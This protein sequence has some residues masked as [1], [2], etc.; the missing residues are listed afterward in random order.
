[1]DAWIWIVLAI[2]ALVVIASIAWGIGRQR[3]STTLREQFGPEYDRTLED[4]DD[5]RAAESELESR[6]ARREQ[7][8]IRPLDAASRQR[9]AEQWEG[10]QAR[11]VDDPEIAVTEADGLIIQVMRDRGYPID[12]FDRRAADVSVDH[13]RVVEHYR[14][15]HEIADRSKSGRATTEDMRK[16]VVHYRALF[17]DLLDQPADMRRSG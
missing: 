11:F 10:V 13:P 16:A 7:F 5:R 15:A 8:D 4:F 6:R 12:D 2:V 1:M 9:Y 3:R 14:D 17:A